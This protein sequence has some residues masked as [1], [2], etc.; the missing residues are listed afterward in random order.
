MSSNIGNCTKANTSAIIVEHTVQVEGLA[1]CSNKLE[2]QL[3]GRTYQGKR[4]RAIIPHH[5]S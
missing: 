1:L 5:D 3:L 4:N 2:R